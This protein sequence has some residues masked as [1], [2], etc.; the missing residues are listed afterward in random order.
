MKCLIARMTAALVLVS[1]QP[2]QA[3]EFN[4]E[5]A[6][7]YDVGEVLGAVLVLKNYQ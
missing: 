7:G 2:M 3:S 1:G 4:D 5:K 6:T